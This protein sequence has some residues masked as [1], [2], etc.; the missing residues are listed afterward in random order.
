MSKFRMNH[1]MF[2]DLIF[3]Q[4]ASCLKKGFYLFTGIYCF[5]AS[6]LGVIKSDYCNSCL[7]I[8][9]IVNYCN[10]AHSILNLLG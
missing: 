2:D 10:A 1:I 9:Q 5:I 6:V 7:Y 4:G 8:F 3:I